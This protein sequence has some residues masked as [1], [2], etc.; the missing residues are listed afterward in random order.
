MT[1][2]MKNTIVKKNDYRMEDMKYIKEEVNRMII[3]TIF[4]CSENV[5]IK[6]SKTIKL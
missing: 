2:N 1:G 6:C 3:K 4:S 5:L